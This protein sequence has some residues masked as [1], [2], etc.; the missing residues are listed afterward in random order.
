M[1]TRVIE[2]GD[3]TIDRLGHAAAAANAG[4]QHEEPHHYGPSIGS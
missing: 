1:E 2:E 4:L 3:P